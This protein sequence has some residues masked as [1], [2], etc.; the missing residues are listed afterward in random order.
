M[1]FNWPVYSLFKIFHPNTE[2]CG[3]RLSFMVG[4]NQSDF[5]WINKQIA[6]KHL[7]RRD[8][9]RHPG[10]MCGFP[11]RSLDKGEGWREENET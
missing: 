10:E 6:F 8:R 9:E 11:L 1:Q 7:V 5:H 4:I 2:V 3:I